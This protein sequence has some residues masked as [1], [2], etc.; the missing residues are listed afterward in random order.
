MATTDIVFTGFYYAIG[1]TATVS[2]AGLDC[3]DYVVSSLGTVTVPI[4]SDTDKLC[5]WANLVQYDVGPYDRD[6]YGD[7]T[8]GVTMADGTGGVQTLYLPVVIGFVY[9]AAGFALRAV[10]QDALKTPQGGGTG[11]T[12]RSHWVSIQL[13]NTQGIALGTLSSAVY[14]TAPLAD[15][16]A[17]VLP[18]N[19]LYTGVWTKPI[20]DNPSFDGQIGWRILRPFPCTVLSLTGFVETAER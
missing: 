10:D 3:G 18:L 4:N 7:A 2:I 19:E 1:Y 9:P 12:R 16:G 14:D 17:N 5:N 8:M 6:T 15:E 11:K 20:D 13:L